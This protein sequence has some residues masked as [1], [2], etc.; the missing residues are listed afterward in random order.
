MPDLFLS[1]AHVDKHWVDTFAALLEQRVN[2]YVGRAKPDRLWKDNRFS[3]NAAISPEIDAQLAQARCLVSILSPGYL[4]SEWC[5]YEL[6]TFSARVGANSGRIFC[7]E[8]DHIPLENKPAAFTPT[9]GY[10][11]WWQDAQSKRTY[12]LA[13][14]HPDYE[15]RLIDLAKDIAATLQRENSPQSPF[16]KGGG[17]EPVVNAVPPSSAS[18]GKRGVGGDFSAQKLAALESRRA[19]LHELLTRQREEL[20]L[21]DDPK[22][23]MRLERDIKA[24]QASADQVEAEITAILATT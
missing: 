19:L 21:T 7:I 11:Y 2:Q 4:A 8:L 13:A 10:R 3:G 9:L 24:A 5:M 16:C 14:N 1:Y 6:A 15:I 22:R 20:D 12:P 17:E 18:F 23:Q